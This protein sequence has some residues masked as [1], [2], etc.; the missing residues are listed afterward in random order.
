MELMTRDRS[1]DPLDDFSKVAAEGFLKTPEPACPL[2]KIP[3]V[4]QHQALFAKISPAVSLL[5]DQS[6]S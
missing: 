1:R 6:S 3:G 4:Q 5:T 2:R